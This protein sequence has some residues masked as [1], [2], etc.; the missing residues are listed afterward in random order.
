MS[1]RQVRVSFSYVGQD[2]GR[3]AKLSSDI[4]VIYVMS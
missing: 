3:T 2:A 4:V 1:H